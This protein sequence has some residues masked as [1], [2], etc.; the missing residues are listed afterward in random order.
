MLTYMYVNMYILQYNYI[1]VQLIFPF[2][3]LNIMR[4]V[5]GLNVCW[6]IKDRM[7]PQHGMFKDMYRNAKLFGMM[8]Y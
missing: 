6:L 5:P 7:N 3:A 8:I 1:Q 2:R 4:S